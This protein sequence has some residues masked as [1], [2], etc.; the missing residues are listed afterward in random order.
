MK[1]ILHRLRTEAE[2]NSIIIQDLEHNAKRMQKENGHLIEK[3]K[4]AL[5]N[6]KK[7]KAV[8]I[9][10]K[11]VQNKLKATEDQLQQTQQQVNDCLSFVIECMFDIIS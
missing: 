2:K 5:A 1:T 6:E 4:E 8:K 9:E 10:L 7:G 3:M 11:S